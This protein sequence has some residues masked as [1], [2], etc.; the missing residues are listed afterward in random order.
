MQFVTN[1]MK[2]AYLIAFKSFELVWSLIAS[3]QVLENMLNVNVN[4][5]GTVV[6]A[7]L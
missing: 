3:D 4:I 2:Q 1:G 6:S 7:H 5:F